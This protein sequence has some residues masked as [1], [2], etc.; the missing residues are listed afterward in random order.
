[1]PAVDDLLIYLGVGWFAG[2]V[3]G[4][5][6][7]GGGLI[8][9]PALVLSFRAQGMDGAVLAHVAVGTS[10][11]TIIITST[12]SMIAHHRHG[13]V[14]WPVFWRL[15]P[16]LVA[17]SWFGAWLARMIPGAGLRTL[18]GIFELL[19]AVQLVTQWRARAHRQLPGVAGLAIVSGL[20]GTVSTLVGIGGGTMTVPFLNW[21]HVNLRKA[22]ATSAACG[23]PIAMAG[24]FG[25]MVF[26]WLDGRAPALAT[27]YVYWPAF[28][29]IAAAGLVT[30]PLGARAAHRL[31]TEVLGKIFAAL[32]ATL[33]VRML[34][35]G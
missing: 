23:L 17:G 29:T 30:A 8:I 9:V 18:F 2:F 34:W 31:P 20:I 3:A 11:A 21:C 10:L 28:A 4:L 25:F 19:V 6:G 12:S 22:V 1:M 27:G 14:Q 15:A 26:G 24:A 32:L 33:G 7:V 13:A 35:F 5:L 16:G